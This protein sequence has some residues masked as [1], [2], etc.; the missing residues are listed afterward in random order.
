MLLISLLFLKPKDGLFVA[1]DYILVVGSTELELALPVRLL[2]DE[3]RAGHAQRVI[4][5]NL[6]LDVFRLEAEKGLEKEHGVVLLECDEFANDRHDHGAELLEGDLKL[7]L[8]IG[9]LLV[10]AAARNIV[11][12]ALHERI[13][14]R[15]LLQELIEAVHEV[16]LEEDPGLLELVDHSAEK[17]GRHLYQLCLFGQV[18]AIFGVDDGH[19][20]LNDLV[21]DQKGDFRIK[22]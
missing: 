17:R 14:A 15:V 10:G 16:H 5:Q 21:V 8:V 4:V 11:E 18:A 9:V 20:A 13:G 12:N 19:V 22:V 2:V 1:K 3:S 7:A 6:I